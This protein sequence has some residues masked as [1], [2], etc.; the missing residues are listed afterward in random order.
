MVGL[1][2]DV[3]IALGLLVM[4]TYLGSKITIKVISEFCFEI[5]ASVLVALIYRHG[6][7]C[8]GAFGR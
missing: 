2:I 8:G 7:M 6:E 5:I 1:I 4:Q 3:D